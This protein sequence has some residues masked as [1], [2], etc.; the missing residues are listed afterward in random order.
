MHG[1]PLD[2]DGDDVD[3]PMIPLVSTVKKTYSHDRSF[4]ASQHEQVLVS[5]YLSV[6]LDSNTYLLLVLLKRHTVMFI[7]L[8]HPNIKRY[9]IS[10]FYV[11]VNLDSNT[12]DDP[13]VPIV[14]LLL[15]FYLS[16]CLIFCSRS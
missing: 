6:Y 12:L 8:M 7:H 16:I 15:S 1:D 13:I 5:F 3:N 9:W 10:N 11:S 14:S 4:D 2:M